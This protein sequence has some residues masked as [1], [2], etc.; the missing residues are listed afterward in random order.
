MTALRRSLVCVV[1]IGAVIAPAPALAQIAAVPS[2]TRLPKVTQAARH[3]SIV[4]LRRRFK[5]EFYLG[6]FRSTCARRISRTRARCSV[7]WFQGDWV[8]SGHTEIW[9]SRR[10][11]GVE[12]NYSYTIR[13]VDTYCYQVQHRP[14]SRCS[15]HYHVS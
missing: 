2:P 1:G 3:Y 5:G 14:L 7:A 8:F 10:A 15:R 12:W 4:A 6:G 9:Y 13:E 11:Q